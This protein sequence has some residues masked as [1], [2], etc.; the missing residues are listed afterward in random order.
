MYLMF[1]KEASLY[2]L[3]WVYETHGGVEMQFPRLLS[4]R[5]EMEVVGLHARLKLHSGK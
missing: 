2:S 1:V 4:T 3:Q 5:N